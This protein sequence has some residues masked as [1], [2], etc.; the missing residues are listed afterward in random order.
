MR[1][2]CIMEIVN[3]KPVRLLG[4]DAVVK[5]D[6][7]LTNYNANREYLEYFSKLAKFKGVKNYIVVLFRASS[8]S[9]KWCYLGH[10]PVTGSATILDIEDALD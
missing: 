8:L 2:V 7:R 4:T 6:G 3:G 9:G 1:Y 10:I 5:C